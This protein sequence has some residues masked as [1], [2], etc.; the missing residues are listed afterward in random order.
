MQDILVATE[1]KFSGLKKK[2]GGAEQYTDVCV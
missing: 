2:G 1:C